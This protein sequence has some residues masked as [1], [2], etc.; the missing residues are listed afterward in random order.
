MR[1]KRLFLNWVLM[2]V[3]GCGGAVPRDG[4]PVRDAFDDT[5]TG[6]AAAKL[7]IRRDPSPLSARLFV[8]VYHPP[9]I[10]P[11]YVPSRVSRDRDM[12]VGEHWIFVKIHDGGW[13][14]EREE[15]EA[16]ASAPPAG[17]EELRALLRRVAR[18]RFDEAVRR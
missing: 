7:S 4:V 2:A 16:D 15:E 17:P 5:T 6:G 13:F 9:E 1:K 8:P 11:L 18:T 12:L 14:P 10:F 3:A